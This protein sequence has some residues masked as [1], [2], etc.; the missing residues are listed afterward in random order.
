[1]SNN[2]EQCWDCEGLRLTTC[3]HSEPPADCPDHETNPAVEYGDSPSKKRALEALLRSARQTGKSETNRRD[4]LRRRLADEQE[5]RPPEGAVRWIVCAAIRH[6][7]TGH[8]V[9]APRHSSALMW[10][11]ME[12]SGIEHW[13]GA[14]QGFLDQFSH[15]HSREE[16]LEIA[17]N[18]GQIRRRCGGDESRLYSENLY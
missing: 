5:F 9:C 2:R 11:Q 13:H 8:T 18:N 10:L 4:C 16:A 17:R 3:P 7:E 15:F 14:E 1:M 6:R 12:L